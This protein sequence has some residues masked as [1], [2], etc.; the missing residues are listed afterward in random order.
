[1]YF[2]GRKKKLI[3]KSVTIK[4]N[5]NGIHTL[6]LSIRQ[7]KIKENIKIKKVYFFTT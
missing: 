1:M 6:G 2:S 7:K 5:L 4:K 3:K